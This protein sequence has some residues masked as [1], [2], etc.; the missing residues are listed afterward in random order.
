MSPQ[1][2]P[3]VSL[4]L[5]SPHWSHE[6]PVGYHLSLIRPHWSPLVSQ[7]LTSP[8]WSHESPVVSHSHESHC[9]L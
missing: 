5:M 8:H 2:S 4:S 3:L 1:W 9:S 7:T 6:S